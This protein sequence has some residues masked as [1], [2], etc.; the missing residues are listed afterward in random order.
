M[1]TVTIS[2]A[3]QKLFDSSMIMYIMYLWTGQHVQGDADECAGCIRHCWWFS[4]PTAARDPGGRPAG[5]RTPE[6]VRTVVYQ[7][8]RCF[9][10]T[11]S[12][13]VSWLKNTDRLSKT[14][15]K[16]LL[17]ADSTVYYSLQIQQLNKYNIIFI[18]KLFIFN[19][20]GEWHKSHDIKRNSEVNRLIQELTPIF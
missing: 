11:C 8:Q 4:R 18:I 5:H 6:W 20:V 15:G 13:S 19:K 9:L 7:Q 3:L 16:R 12:V 14:T 17:T 10:C 2:G 1:K